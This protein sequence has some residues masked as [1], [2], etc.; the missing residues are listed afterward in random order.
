MRILHLLLM[1][2]IAITAVSLDLLPQQDKT[3]Y[4]EDVPEIVNAAPMKYPWPLGDL[5][6]GVPGV[7]VVRVALGSKGNVEGASAVSGDE[8]LIPACL[9]NVSKWNFK[10]NRQKS[11]IVVYEFRSGEGPCP[12]RSYSLIRNRNLVRVMLCWPEH[13]ILPSESMP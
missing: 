8:R 1:A 12:D 6:V 4:D 7:V 10:A 5:P 13:P 9:S 2:S 11:V 3:I